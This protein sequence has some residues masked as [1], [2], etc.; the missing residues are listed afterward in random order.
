MGASTLVLSFVL[1]VPTPGMTFAL[2]S[3]WLMNDIPFVLSNFTIVTFL[4]RKFKFS[5]VILAP[6]AGVGFSFSL[7]DLVDF[8]VRDILRSLDS[9][10]RLLTGLYL[11]GAGT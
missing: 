10:A 1:Y 2:F 3:V 8:I 5:S 11:L 9:S 6:G 4:S 7:R